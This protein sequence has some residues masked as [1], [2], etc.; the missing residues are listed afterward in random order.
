[1]AQETEIKVRIDDNEALA[2]LREMLDL[3]SNIEDKL[4]GLSMPDA[5]PPSAP[6][7]PS[8][9][10]AA[11]GAAGAAGGAP[12]GA[13][14]GGALVAK[15][16]DI[17]TETFGAG[18]GFTAGGLSSTIGQ[19]LRSA[20]AS[21]PFGAGIPT[22][23][24]G[25][26]FGLVGK[27][28]EQRQQ[29]LGQVAQLEEL[30]AG[31]LG[32]VDTASAQD[33]VTG[34]S[35]TLTKYGFDQ[36]Q[37][38]QLLQ[39]VASGAGFKVTGGE[40]KTRAE[41][42]ARSEKL[43]IPASVLASTAGA[44]AQATGK[45]VG[46]AL[47][48]SLALKNFA[49]KGLDLRGEGVSSFLQSFAS[50]V[51]QFTAQGIKIDPKSLA[52]ELKGIAQATGTRGERPGQILSALSGVAEGAGGDITST[53]QQMATMSVEAEATRGATDIFSFL[54]NLERLKGSPLGTKEAITK[55]F[56]FGR[57]GASILASI[58]GIGTKDAR[59][60]LGARA[61]G[62]GET[63]RISGT[64]LEETLSVAGAQALQQKQALETVR[65]DED[66]NKK[67]I[68][69]TGEMQTS[70]LKLSENEQVI[71]SV[72]EGINTTLDIANKTGE[73]VAKALE[74]LKRMIK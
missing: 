31:V 15:S 38:A 61:V 9:G 20:S 36:S 3:V 14:S 46:S 72:A 41:E 66:L 26:Y 65:K 51:D 52:S 59:K 10:G 4:S 27:S 63:E 45:S 22:A 37:T 42:L 67:L 39:S 35:G 70:L 21:M 56:G 43:G 18:G 16:A 7:A 30:E 8:G 47:D 68:E 13:P 25:V 19:Q 60:L 40:L 11:A 33:L 23:L 58:P 69:I 64:A 57:T 62:L 34:V 50:T 48:S 55:T 73:K 44:I 12:G 29:M 32:A 54:G 74:T 28:L 5:S 17:A 6:G 2:S 24:A 71:T 49:E 1:M 53:L